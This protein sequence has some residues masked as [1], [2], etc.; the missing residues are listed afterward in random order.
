MS[1]NPFTDTEKVTEQL[2]KL[3]L[4]SNPIIQPQEADRPLVDQILWDLRE[5][6]AGLL[7]KQLESD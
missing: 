4:N 7:T 2:A 6:H 5:E 3:D 1:I